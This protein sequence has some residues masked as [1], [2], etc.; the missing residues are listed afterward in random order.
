MGLPLTNRVRRG[1]DL[2]AARLPL[3][4]LPCSSRSRQRHE[5]IGVSWYILA[6]TH[7]TVKV[8]CK[9]SSSLFLACSFISRRCA[10]RSLRPPYLGVILN[11]VRGIS[12]L[13]RLYRLENHLQ[14]WHLYAMTLITGIGS[15]MYWA[16]VNALVQEVIPTSQISG[17]NA[18]VL[19]A[20]KAACSSRERSSAFSTT[21]RA[22][23]ILA[24]DG[25]TYFL[26]AYCLYQ[27]RRGYVSPARIS[28]RERIFESTNSREALE[29]AEAARIAEP[30]F[31]R[32]V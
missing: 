6:S 24:I 1:A 30:P 27:V 8:S 29:S 13:H 25:A 15:A 23:G 19:S 22:S 4:F 14:L 12:S 16:T 5:L 3:F 28:T 26:S 21:A 7:S 17:A 11:F 20:C 18:A 2:G 9:S 31:T 32:D 10:D